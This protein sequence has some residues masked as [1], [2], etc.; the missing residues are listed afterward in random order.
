MEPV[1]DEEGFPEDKRPVIRTLNAFHA[2]LEEGRIP[3]FA[4]GGGADYEAGVAVFYIPEENAELS[5]CP[6]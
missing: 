6:R 5:P 3:R 1:Y 4:T 2:A